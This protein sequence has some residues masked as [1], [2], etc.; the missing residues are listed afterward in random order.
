[1]RT[2]DWINL[3]ICSLISNL[4]GLGRLLSTKNKRPIRLSEI[5]RNAIVSMSIGVGVFLLVYAFVPAAKD[6]S[7][8]VFAA[9]YFAG[10]AGPWAVNALI[11][12][13]AVDKG[14]GKDNNQK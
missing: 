5:G 12:K 13:Y 11:D 14:F 4:G 2:E 8:V 9:G 1:M 6:N 3:V 10:W 7:T